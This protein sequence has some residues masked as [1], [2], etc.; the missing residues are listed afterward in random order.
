[1]SLGANFL[2]IIKML[3]VLVCAIMKK[4]KMLCLVIRLPRL[5]TMQSF[6]FS[7]YSVLTH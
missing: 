6:A 4:V 7:L 3:N 5:L 2:A 1:M